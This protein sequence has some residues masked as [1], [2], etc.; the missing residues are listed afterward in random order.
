M[1]ASSRTARSDSV[2]EHGVRD[3][4]EDMPEVALWMQAMYE[5]LDNTVSILAEQQNGPNL[6]NN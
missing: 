6:L 5:E 2:M 4:G 1:V 3:E